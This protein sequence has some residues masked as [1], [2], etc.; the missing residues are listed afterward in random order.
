MLFSV[1]FMGV[2]ML[3]KNIGL[4]GLG[5]TR[6]L[7]CILILTVFCWFV[8]LLLRLG[9]ALRRADGGGDDE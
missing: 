1:K 6:G 7:S 8:S 2:W 4:E 5:W 3:G 9:D